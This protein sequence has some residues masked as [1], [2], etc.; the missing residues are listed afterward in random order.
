MLKR[1]NRSKT[2]ELCQWSVGFLHYAL[3]F[4]SFRAAP[5]S[6]CHL[7]LLFIVFFMVERFDEMC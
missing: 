4:V 3:V 2:G 6:C 5:L 1:L 7:L